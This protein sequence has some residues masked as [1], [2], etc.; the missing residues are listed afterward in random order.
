MSD[1]DELGRRIRE[2]L[3]KILRMTRVIRQP[4]REGKP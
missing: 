2:H 1:A 4:Y 3:R